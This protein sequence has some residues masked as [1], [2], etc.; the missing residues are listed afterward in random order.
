MALIG[1]YVH[2][3]AVFVAV[4][5]CVIGVWIDVCSCYWYVM[6]H[7]RQGHSGVPIVS[8]IIYM[9]IFLVQEH[10]KSPL[11]PVRCGQ[12]LVLLHVVCQ[13]CI[14]ML[15]RLFLK[16]TRGTWGRVWS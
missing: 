11:I 16:V 10:L 9:L 1:T 6:S 14:P 4:A 13:F 8:L 15:D 2:M 5:F 12:A 3:L 7:R